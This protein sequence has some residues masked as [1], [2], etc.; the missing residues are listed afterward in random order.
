MVTLPKQWAEKVGV[1]KN[2]RVIVEQRPDGSLLLT[3]MDLA[4]KGDDSKVIDCDRIEDPKFLFRMLLGCYLAGFSS[5]DIVSTERMKWEFSSVANRFTEVAIGM[6]IM[7]ESDRRILIKDL[8]DQTEMQLAKG[9][10]R[11]RVLADNMLTSAFAAA[12]GEGDFIDRDREIDRM[13]WLVARQTCI[14]FRN[15]GSAP[16]GAEPQMILGV[17]SVS[18]IIERIGDHACKIYEVLNSMSQEDRDAISGTVGD[19]GTRIV[20]LFNDSMMSWK[21]MT[22]EDANACVDAAKTLADECHT[23]PAG[24][25]ATNVLVNSMSRICEYSGDLAEHAINAAVSAR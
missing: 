23:I 1:E 14:A 2:D 4:G 22:L 20:G 7:E 3:P 9:V 18:R 6:E 24:D 11:M 16:Q 17:Y 15:P 5:I 12:G 19:L 10:G 21:N 25:T 8:V 13:D